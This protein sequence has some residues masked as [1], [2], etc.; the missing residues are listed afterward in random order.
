MMLKIFQV[1]TLPTPVILKNNSIAKDL[2]SMHSRINK[3]YSIK[4][5]KMFKNKK[6]KSLLSTLSTISWVE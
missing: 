4:D 6:K 2:T 1:Y 3:N 5:L